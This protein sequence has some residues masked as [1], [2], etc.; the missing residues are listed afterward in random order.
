MEIGTLVSADSHLVEPPDIFETRL[1]AS[2]R[3]RAPRMELTIDANGRGQHVWTLDGHML[4]PLGGGAPRR[5]ARDR[6][7]RELRALWSELDPAAYEP[8]AY[9]V[10]LAVDGVAAAVVQPT[11][12]LVWWRLPD[13]ALLDALFRAQNDHMIEFC[14]RHPGQLNGVA[15]LNVDD[16]A[17][18][19]HELR[20]CRE[21]GLVGALIP[22]HPGAAPPYR[23]PCYDPLWATAQELAVP[24][25][26]HLATVRASASGPT[27]SIAST[28]ALSPAARSVNDY[29]VRLSLAEIIFGGVFDRF[30]QLRVGSVE[31]EIAW[32]PH[33]LR[34]MDFI[35]ERRQFLTGGWRSASGQRPSEL[36]RSNM[37]ATFIEDDLG[38]ELRAHIGIDNILW[39]ND[40]PHTE[41]SWPNSRAI[42]G[43]MMRGVPGSDARAMTNSNTARLFG[44]EVAPS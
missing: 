26:L 15:C 12:G 18:S 28:T 44:I 7:N 43:D 25:C 35:Y 36:F 6:E 3:P 29:W 31:H 38:V 17:A 39:G 5:G 21:L 23:D 30:P 22:V 41:S 33:W 2:M 13:S 40:F 32:I 9:V 14:S 42:V 34:N 16:V 27:N 10:A 8:D 11:A 20:R 19:C 37:F 4:T 24:L 1:D